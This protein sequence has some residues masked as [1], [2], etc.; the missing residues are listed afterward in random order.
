MAK[1][2]YQTRVFGHTCYNVCQLNF[3]IKLTPISNHRRSCIHRK[4]AHLQ[5]R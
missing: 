2:R 3:N 5:C 1:D 4:E